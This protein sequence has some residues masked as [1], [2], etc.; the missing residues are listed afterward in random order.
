MPFLVNI[1]TVFFEII[2][3]SLSYFLWDPVVDFY[4][5]CVI[6]LANYMLGIFGIVILLLTVILKVTEEFRFV[7]RFSN[8]TDLKIYTSVDVSKFNLEIFLHK[9]VIILHVARIHIFWA[10]KTLLYP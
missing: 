3:F 4:T 10:T 9:F 5:H 1:Y 6:I 7:C 2:I 8:T